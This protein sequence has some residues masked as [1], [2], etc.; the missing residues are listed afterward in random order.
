LAGAM[1]SRHRRKK[2]TQR[3]NDRRARKPMKKNYP[4]LCITSVFSA[5]TISY[6]TH[7]TDYEQDINFS[8]QDSFH[9][10]EIFS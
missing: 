3:P 9:Q 2:R 4:Q 7:S 10:R 8:A 5:T 6:P 1:I